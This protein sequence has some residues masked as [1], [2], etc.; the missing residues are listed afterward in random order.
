MLYN[1]T[2]VRYI[3]Y[4]ESTAVSVIVE[5]GTTNDWDVQKQRRPQQPS[6]GCLTGKP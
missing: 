4:Y 1:T 6:R 5:A 3:V 2:V